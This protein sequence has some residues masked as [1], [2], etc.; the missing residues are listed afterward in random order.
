[1]Q[2][3]KSKNTDSFN[4]VLFNMIKFYAFF[5]FKQTIFIIRILIKY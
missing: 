4:K 2:F 1:M 3:V 5:I